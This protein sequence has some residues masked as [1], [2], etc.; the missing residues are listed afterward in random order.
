MDKIKGIIKLVLSGKRIEASTWS[1]F[2]VI[3]VNCSLPKY[4]SI[5]NY[6]REYSETFSLYG[7]TTIPK[8]S[9]IFY[10]GTVVISQDVAN[11]DGQ[12]NY[13]DEL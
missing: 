3:V 7:I 13:Q 2:P 12:A 11:F 4:E 9:L 6:I 1:Q 10:N 5:S 8:S